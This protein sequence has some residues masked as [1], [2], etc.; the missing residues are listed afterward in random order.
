MNRYWIMG[1]AVGGMLV[2]GGER[3]SAQRARGIDVSVYQ[4]SSINWAQVAGSGIQ[5]AFIRSS[6][7]LSSTDANF[8]Q[9]INGARAHGI[10]AGAYY[11]ADPNY[12]SAYTAS[13]SAQHFVDVTR[14]YIGAGYLRPVL[15]LEENYGLSVAGLS[16]WANQFI[17]TVKSETGV[18][19]LIYC[20]TNYAAN[21]LNSSIADRGL[22]IAN[23]SNYGDPLTTGSPPIG[24]FDQW[25]FWQYTSSGNT[26][27]FPSVAGISGR[28]DLD[29]AHGDI[30]YVRQ[31]LVPEPGEF[32]LMGLGVLVL[33]PMRRR[34]RLAATH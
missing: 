3:A 1:L 17:D 8:Q 20:N 27:G 4:G 6:Y 13:A 23:W 2:M 25:A 10:L 5:F 18:E 28:V 21:L 29:V 32:A 19:P 26:A 14:D 9:N 7:G 31:F 24:N 22:W 30:S 12:T 11:F 15:D 33:L 16:D 34:R